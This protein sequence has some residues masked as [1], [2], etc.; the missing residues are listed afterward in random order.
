MFISVYVLLAMQLVSFIPFQKEAIEAIQ[1]LAEMAELM[2]INKSD[3]EFSNL[4]GTLF[5]CLD[6][7]KTRLVHAEA[8][9]SICL[10]KITFSSF[11][12]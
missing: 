8:E 9:N 4:D 11:S 12:Y 10:K 3:V 7:A 2:C 6:E 5:I 1:A